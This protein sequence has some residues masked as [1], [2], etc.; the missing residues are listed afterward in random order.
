VRWYDDAP[1]LEHPVV[2]A[3]FTGW[4]DAADAASDALRYVARATQAVPVGELEPDGFIDYQASRP[5]VEVVDGV[6]RTITWPA[7]RFLASA[8]ADLLLVT[9]A[10][11][12]FRWRELCARIA[13]VALTLDAR[14]VVTL[15]ALLGD[16][17]HSRPVRVTGTATDDNL[18]D[19]L[20]LQRSLYE[21][22][23]GIVGALHGA[24]REA[25]L[26]SVSLWAPV[27]HYAAAP[28][29]P[30]ATAALVGRLCS[31]CGLAVDTGRL[32]IA[33][34]AWERQVDALVRQDDTLAE[35]VA[36]LEEHFDTGEGGD[37]GDEG[38]DAH[39]AARDVPSGDALAAELERYLRDLDD[40]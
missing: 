27:P 21:G 8:P 19:R 30:K 4:N 9:G 2:V 29:C 11:P 17:P 39:P 25:G 40:E 37:G 1:A 10:E 22:P 23:T 5:H 34:A 35:Y 12:T 24:C 18:V 36:T 28:P 14:I 13:D 32:E 33:S 31:L 7:T 6:A 20:D 16:T 15:G 26:A 3:A 38:G